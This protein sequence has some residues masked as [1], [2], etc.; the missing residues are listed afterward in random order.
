M[1]PRRCSTP[2]ERR[3]SFARRDR[4]R[5]RLSEL[6][7]AVIQRAPAQRRGVRPDMLQSFMEVGLP[8]RPT[9]TDDEIVGMVIWIMFAGFHTSSNTATWTVVELARHPEYAARVAREI[10][11]IYDGAERARA[12]PRCASSRRSSASCSRCCGST[13]RSSR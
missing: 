7:T 11:S 12:S 3:R 13:R 8:R 2:T 6:V 9:L 5:A 1:S 10:D 4:S